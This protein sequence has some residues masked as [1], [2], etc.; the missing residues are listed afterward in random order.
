MEKWAKNREKVQNCYPL[1]PPRHLAGWIDA[2][3]SATARARLTAVRE[4]ESVRYTVGMLCDDIQST[5][6]MGSKK[7]K[8]LCIKCRHVGS[9]ENG[10][11]P[12][13]VSIFIAVQNYV[14]SGNEGIPKSIRGNINCC[15]I[16]KSGNMKEIDSLTTD[17]IDLRSVHHR[18]FSFMFEARVDASYSFQVF[19]SRKASQRR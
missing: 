19:A 5:P 15:A 4:P 11:P 9:F 1:S 14:A 7:F 13:G 16:W 18:P 12:I 8:N 17:S 2:A 10:E 6:L 3:R